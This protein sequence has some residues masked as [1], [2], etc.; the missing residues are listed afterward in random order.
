MKI[1]GDKNLLPT[2]Q[3]KPSTKTAEQ[4]G[5]GRTSAGDKVSFSSVLQQQ[6]PTAGSSLAPPTSYSF[7]GLHAP[8]FE[9]LTATEAT[10]SATDL[11]RAAR[12]EELKQ[13][14]AEGSYQ[15]DLKQVAG[16]LLKFLGQGTLS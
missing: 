2:S 7:E 3:V 16:S 11:Q 1:H 4:A 9:E 6:A 13:Q 10:S 14:V 5:E 8:R 15:P 12:L